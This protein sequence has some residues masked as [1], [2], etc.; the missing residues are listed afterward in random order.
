MKGIVILGTKN[1]NPKDIIIQLIPFTENV[2][3]IEFR[4]M[5]NGTIRE[6]STNVDVQENVEIG[7]KVIEI[8]DEKTIKEIF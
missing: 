3:K 4:R 2:G 8:Y 5:S 6:A 7:G 1:Y